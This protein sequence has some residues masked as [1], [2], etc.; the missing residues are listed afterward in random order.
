MPRSTQAHAV[1]LK[2]LPRQTF[3]DRFIYVV[4]VAE[5]LANLPQIYTIYAHKNAA[6]VSLTS[7]V[8]YAAFALTWLWYGI[9]KRERPMVVGA[10]LFLTTDTAVIIGA[11]MYGGRF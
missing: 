9:H 11:M 3:I 10:T 1:A 2:R 5:P 8:L 7:W 6:G 4:A